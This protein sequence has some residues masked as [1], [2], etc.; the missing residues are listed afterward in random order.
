MEAR[1]ENG[2][3]PLHGAT[4]S[5]AVTALL[6]AG[7]NLEARDEYGGTPLHRA[8]EL[9]NNPAA[10]KVIL[11][12]GADTAARNAAG[13]T[14]WDLVQ[15]NDALKGSHAYWRLNDARF[16][17]SYSVFRVG[18]C[19]GGATPKLV[20]KLEPEYSEEAREAKL[21]GKVVLNVVV[22]RDGTPRIVRVMQS[23]GLGL[24]E[25]AIEAV[26]QWRF[27]PGMCN[28]QAVDVKVNVEVTFRLL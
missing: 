20:Y 2:L 24:D 17:S 9:S 8:A 16:K 15:V 22:Q 23:L 10:I 28:G 14:P 18:E 11:D 6:Q 27:N 3:T 21:Q 13:K 19:G 12:A 7:A 25:K 1:N 4:T 5:E 26:R